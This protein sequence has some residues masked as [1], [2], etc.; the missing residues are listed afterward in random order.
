MSPKTPQRVFLADA[1]AIP[2]KKRPAE[3]TT[4]E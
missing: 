4:I 3:V 1:E 2:A